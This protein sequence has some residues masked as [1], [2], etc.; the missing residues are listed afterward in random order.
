MRPEFIVLL[1]PLFDEDF[2]FLRGIENLAI[3][4]LIAKLAVK[5]TPQLDHKRND[6]HDHKPEK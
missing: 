3:K 1:S 5:L 4:L 2:G 6:R